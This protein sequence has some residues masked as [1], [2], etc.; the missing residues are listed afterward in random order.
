MEGLGNLHGTGGN[1]LTVSGSA[2]CMTVAAYTNEA[3][4][5]AK[6]RLFWNPLTGNGR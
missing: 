6:N 4:M 2:Q 5:P 1:V 3:S